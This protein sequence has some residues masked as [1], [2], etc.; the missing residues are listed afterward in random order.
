MNRTLHGRRRHALKVVIAALAI[1]A[2]GACSSSGSKAKATTTAPSQSSGAS[3][4]GTLH[5]VVTNDDGYQ[6]DGIDALTT[7]LE[8]LPN[9]NVTVVAPAD[10]NSGAGGKTTPGTLTV[11]DAKTKSGKP[12]KA[13]HGTPADTIRVALDQLGLKP[14]LV[15][16]G[17]NQGQNLGPLADISGTVGAA[18]AAV[19]RG[20]PALAVSSGTHMFDYAAAVPFVTQWVNAHRADI[21]AKKAPVQVVSLNVPSCVTGKVRGLKEVAADTNKADAALAVQ[22]QNCTSTQTDFPNDVVAFNNG[23]ATESVLAANAA[24]AA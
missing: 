9:T 13:V 24:P 20:I 5:I 10:N 19:A 15:V 22:D 1:L 14:D 11:T 12:A 18:R 6:S 8:S 17:I 21:L 7:A 16:S 3:S 2:L 4:G 23:Y